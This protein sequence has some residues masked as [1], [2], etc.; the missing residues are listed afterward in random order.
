MIVESRDRH[1]E[2]VERM[3]ALVRALV[4]GAVVAAGTAMGGPTSAAVTYDP[5]TKKGYVARAD[6][7][8][9]FGWD[10]ATLKARAAGIVFNHDFWT[11][12][13]Y[14]VTC[15]R[16]TFPLVHH[17][18]FG[19]YELFDAAVSDKGRGAKGYTGKLAGFWL[20]GP[21]FGISGTTA[22]PAPGQ[23]CPDDAT[24]KVTKATLRATSKGWALQAGSGDLTRQLRTGTTPA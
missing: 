21:R 24:S 7:L 3:R 18:E 19:R 16:R 13:T 6:L 20:T 4:A 9:A 8:A 11:D 12:D 17:R 1:T 22:G 5:Q 15:G 14:E 23:P 2:E 10:D